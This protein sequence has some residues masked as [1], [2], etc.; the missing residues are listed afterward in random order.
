MIIWINGAF[1]SGKTQTAFELQ[2]R[3]TGAFVYDPENAG[4]FIRDNIPKG[5]ELYDFQDFIMWRE[6]NY[7]MLKYITNKHDG[8][9]IVPMTITNPQYFEEIIGKLQKDGFIIK[10]FVLGASKSTILRRL[11][12]R[13]EGENSWPAQQIDRCI[14]AFSMELFK[15]YIDTE[16]LSVQEVV[17]KIG[18]LSKI[19]L[20]P[21]NRSKFKRLSHR[22]LTQI[23][24]IRR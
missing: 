13:F 15:Q 3:L 6:F 8:I 19:E 23:S 18:E 24:H 21:D 2:R 9:I 1:G 22:L 12:S 11:K 16:N 17:E 4:Y 5:L 14:E 7:S 20:L 10:H